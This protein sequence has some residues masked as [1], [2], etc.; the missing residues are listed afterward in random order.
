MLGMCLMHN[1]N[2]L[3]ILVAY[4]YNIYIYIYMMINH[5]TFFSVNLFFES[6]YLSPMVSIPRYY[7]LVSYQS[8]NYGIE[9]S[10]G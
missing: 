6:G 5:F 1:V 10:L 7:I 3:N 4:I 9:P 2:I 8:Q